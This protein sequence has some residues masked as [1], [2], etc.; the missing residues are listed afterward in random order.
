MLA[1][2]GL[3]FV[4]KMTYVFSTALVLP[5]TQGALYVST[6]DARIQ[7]FFEA[8]PMRPGQQFVDLGCGDGRVICGATRRYGVQATGYELNPVAYL[9]ARLRC[10]G[11]RGARVVWRDFWDADLSR[12][13]V[14]F[15]YLFPDVMQRLAGKIR[16]EARPGALVI[17][18]NF[19]VPDFVPRQVLRPTGSL[20]HDPIYIYRIETLTG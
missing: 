16:A 7:A 5:V 9:R 10:A 14:I 19:P 12:A 15:C 1:L 18:C 3:L 20:H 2:A 6:S 17:S 11:K 8:V 4:L 13:D